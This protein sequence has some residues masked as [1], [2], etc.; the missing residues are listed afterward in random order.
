VIIWLDADSLPRKVR[1]IV[2]RAA[3]REEV[4]AVFVAN[5]GVPFEECP[6][7]RMLVTPDGVTADECILNN[8]APYD[9]A[10]TRDIPLAA[11]LLE[12]EVAVIN[13]RGNRFDRDSIA[14]RLSQ[15]DWTLQLK[16]AGLAGPGGRS[17]DAG[18]VKRFADRFDR[19]FR[20]LLLL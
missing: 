6:S 2:A 14:E 12:K 10:V 11:R 3:C 8:A 7:A 5:R 15:R 19:E 20:R 18:D 17:Y 4:E 13:D 9:L 1:D 16:E